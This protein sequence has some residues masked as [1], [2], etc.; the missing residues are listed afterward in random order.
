M[1]IPFSR[2]HPLR[3][4]LTSSYY[5]SPL[6]L[7]PLVIKLGFSQSFNV[8]CFRV[9]CNGGPYQEESNKRKKK[10]GVK[11][12]ISSKSLYNNWFF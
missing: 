6:F 1:R 5:Q 12:E 11:N 8:Y 10:R 7:V 4:S 9:L 3:M 2:S